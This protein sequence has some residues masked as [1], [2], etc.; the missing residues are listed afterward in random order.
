MFLSVVGQNRV[1]EFPTTHSDPLHNQSLVSTLGLHKPTV[2]VTDGSEHFC[3]SSYDLAS[4]SLRFDPTK[5]PRQDDHESSHRGKVG[6]GDRTELE[7]DQD[8]FKGEVWTSRSCLLSVTSTRRLLHPPYLATIPLDHDV[9]ASSMHLLP[10][11]P[12][13]HPRIS[14][15]PHLTLLPSN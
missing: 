8:W 9:Q 13:R 14:T 6:D 11:N 12:C 1:F 15:H 4:H 2:D 7:Q 10:R 5:K 3:T